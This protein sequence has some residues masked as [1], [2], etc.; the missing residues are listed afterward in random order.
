V[1]DTSTDLFSFGA[2]LYKMASTAENFRPIAWA[3][4][5]PGLSSPS[6]RSVG[7]EEV[8]ERNLK[9]PYGA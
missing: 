3:N 9:C 7:I 6:T 4:P 1:P 5:R 2:L 8:A